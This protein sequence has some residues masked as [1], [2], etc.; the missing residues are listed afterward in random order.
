MLH[1]K[2]NL[3]MLEILFDT[4][5]YLNLAYAIQILQSAK[6]AKIFSTAVA[7]TGDGQQTVK[8][9]EEKTK[10]HTHSYCCLDYAQVVC[11]LYGASCINY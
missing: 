7:A 9:F 2:R 3:T 11:D 4:L 6:G 1:S 5:P 8:E 10:L